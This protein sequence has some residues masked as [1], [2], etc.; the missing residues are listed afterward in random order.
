LGPFQIASTLCSAMLPK[1]KRS[2]VA[3]MQQGTASPW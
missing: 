3:I 2:G 1:L